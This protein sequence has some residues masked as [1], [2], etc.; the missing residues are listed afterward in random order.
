MSR[1]RKLSTYLAS[2]LSV[3][4]LAAC[5][6]T[7]DPEHG[8]TAEP[9][10]VPEGTLRIFADKNEISADGNDEVT[11]TV[12]FGSEDVSNAKTLQIIR[13]YGGEEKYMAYGANKFSTVTAGT[14]EFTAK[15]YYGGNY[16]T[17]NV[18]TVEAEQFFTGEEKSYQQRVFGT[19]FT[20][21]GCTSCPL[22]AKAIKELQ[23]DHPGK[24]SVVAFHA[25]MDQI[26]D[27]MAIAETY[28]FKS[29]LGGFTGLPA[30][31]FNMKKE[32]Y[33]AEAAYREMYASEIDSYSPQCGVSIQ[34][35][36]AEEGK[37]DI[38]VGITSNTPSVYRYLVFI[39]EDGIVADQTGD[40]NYVHYNVV[41]AVLT[42]AKGE[43]LNDNLPLTS[44]VEV[45]VNKTLTLNPVWNSDNLRVVAAATLSTDG[46]Y[47]FVVNNVAECKLGEGVDYQYAE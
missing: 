13:K 47:N 25:D 26:Y 43:K 21:T 31:F 10:V 8:G 37:Y 9:D 18:V 28:E 20:S 12:M 44:G 32:T 4:C 17:D 35:T 23:N 16:Y 39:V 40:P 11:F 27:P 22:A 29:L 42:D 3:I 45:V 34:T 19:Y 24:I 7:M 36:E 14:Y 38:R 41:R 6:G 33:V 1:M 46:G 30:F 2:V 5:S 15:Y